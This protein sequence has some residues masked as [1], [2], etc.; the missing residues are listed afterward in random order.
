M[1][2]ITANPPA[3]GENKLVDFMSNSVND[4]AVKQEDSA[5]TEI[6]PPI[7][8]RAK[9]CGFG[10]WLY[11][12]ALGFLLTF[13]SSLFYLIDTLLPIYQ[14]GLLFELYGENWKYAVAIIYETAIHILFVIF[15]VFLFYLAL[16][17]KKLLRNMVINLYLINFAYNVS[18]YLITNSI[19]DMATHE[20]MSEQGRNIVKSLI[21]CLIWIPYFINSKRVKNTY[22][23]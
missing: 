15:P 1:L 19:E 23:Y 4:L 18:L 17:K 9:P 11:L 8:E 5:T 22:I 3:D 7:E 21:T 13:G 14:N 10:G 20:F 2:S 16:K 6:L 12:V